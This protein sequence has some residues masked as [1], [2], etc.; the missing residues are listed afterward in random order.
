MLTR[1]NDLIATPATRNGHQLPDERDGPILELFQGVK[2]GNPGAGEP[3][4]R[5]PDTLSRAKAKARCNFNPR[6][7]GRGSYIVPH[8]QP[9]RDQPRNVSQ[10]EKHPTVNNES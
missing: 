9:S 4:N 3:A 7:T 10:H 1:V 5:H 6:V 2:V 8:N